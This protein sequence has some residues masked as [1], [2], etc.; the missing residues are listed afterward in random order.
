LSIRLA[1]L[2]DI[3]GVASLVERYCYERHGFRRR[4]GF[5]LLDKTLQDV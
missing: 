5:E 1:T 4:A 2:G 3:E